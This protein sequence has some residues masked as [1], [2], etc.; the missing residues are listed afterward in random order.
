MSSG[1]NDQQDDK[2]QKPIIPVKTSDE[3]TPDP[4][5]YEDSY[6]RDAQ[7]AADKPPHHG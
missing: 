6:S 7:I 4:R 1:A 3:S 5:D 2:D